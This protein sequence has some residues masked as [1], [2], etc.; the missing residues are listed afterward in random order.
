MIAVQNLNADEDENRGHMQEIIL[1]LC[2]RGADLNVRDKRGRTALMWAILDD[3]DDE[4]LQVQIIS[5]LC[6]KGADVNVCSTNGITPLMIACG[7]A[8][9]KIV[10]EL[11][12]RGA[13]VNATSALLRPSV[14]FSRGGGLLSEKPLPKTMTWWLYFKSALT[15]RSF[16]ALDFACRSESLEIASLLLTAGAAKTPGVKETFRVC[17]EGII[18]AEG[19][20][21]S[22]VWRRLFQYNNGE[23]RPNSGLWSC[24]SPKARVVPL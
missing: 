20:K 17:C 2:N 18:C 10:E 7:R 9:Q 16:S 11:L 5:I 14:F 8:A 1:E 3:D 19:E 12:A 22:P 24:F 21:G 15:R 13:N 4:D 23:T 6:D